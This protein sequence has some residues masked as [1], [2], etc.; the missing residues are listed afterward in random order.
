MVVGL[1]VTADPAEFS[2]QELVALVLA[3]R[4]VIEQLRVELAEQARLIRELVAER[5]AVHAELAALRLAAGKDSSNSGKPPS[6]DSP[7]IRPRAK[8]SA[9]NTKSG[10]R[11]GKQ[12]GD[13]SMTLRQVSE[14]DERV[15][16]PA[17]ACG[18]GADL[19]G[20]PVASVTR[21][22]VFE[23]APPPPP[24]VTEYEIAVKICPRCGERSN[25]PVPEHVTG[26]VQ[27]APAVKARGVLLNLWHHVPFRRA[28]ELMRDLAGVRI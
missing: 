2:R 24:T 13:P 5:D 1:V 19:S 16:V 11:P 4:S 27:F 17:Q 3:Q 23:C 21:R 10:R 20:V 7:F 14:P 26:R 22:Q 9:F 18:C 12:P 15:Q 28:A 8:G 25:G 6:S